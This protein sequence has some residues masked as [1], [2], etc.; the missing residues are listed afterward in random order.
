[1][2]VFTARWLEE[3]HNAYVL[4]MIGTHVN[5]ATAGAGVYAK[6]SSLKNTTNTKIRYR[7]E[8]A[9]VNHIEAGRVW[10]NQGICI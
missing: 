7:I 4:V 2:L 5:D 10:N 9:N 8:H 6:F 3:Q 1:M